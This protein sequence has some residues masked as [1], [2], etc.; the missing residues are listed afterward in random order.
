MEVCTTQPDTGAG[1]AG[2]GRQE[3]QNTLA[4]MLADFEAEQKAKGVK[5]ASENGFASWEDY[6]EAQKTD[7]EKRR[8]ADARPV[9]EQTEVKGLDPRK[10]FVSYKPGRSGRW[11]DPTRCRCNGLS[12]HNR[13]LCRILRLC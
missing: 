3:A 7:W 4:R 13:S 12:R 8:L 11:Y 9:R 5:I 6:E 2:N 1:A 10:P